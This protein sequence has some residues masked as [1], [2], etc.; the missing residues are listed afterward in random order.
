M[1]RIEQSVLLWLESRFDSVQKNRRG[2]PDFVVEHDGKTFGFEVK[3]VQRPSML[4]HRLREYIY[5]AYYELKEG[6]F[7]V[8]AI[9]WIVANPSE[10]D[11]L[12]RAVVRM[13]RNEMPDSLR[14]IIGVFDDPESGGV[15]FVPYEDFSY[16]ATRPRLIEPSTVA[17]EPE[18]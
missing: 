16:D 14:I 10:V 5:R 18:R 17:A 13:P 9:I 1:L 3:I 6:R 2:F 8:F 4:F 11:E 7:S 15:G 12:K